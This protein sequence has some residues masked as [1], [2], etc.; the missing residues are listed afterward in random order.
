MVIY[1]NQKNGKLYKLIKSRFYNGQH[2]HIL[3]QAKKLFRVSDRNL[4]Q[5][6]LQLQK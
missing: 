1:G 5:D 4:K 6:F 3:K 2:H